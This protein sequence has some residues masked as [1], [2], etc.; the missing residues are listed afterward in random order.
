MQCRIRADGSLFCVATRTP[1]REKA[2]GS[3]M[4]A[5][6]SQRAMVSRGVGMQG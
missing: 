3:V 2:L 5:R 6:C 1:D 4:S